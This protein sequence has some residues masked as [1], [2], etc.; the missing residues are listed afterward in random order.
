[1]V[2]NYFQQNEQVFREFSERLSRLSTN[3]VR[4][5]KQAASLASLLEL[6]LDHT[7]EYDKNSLLTTREGGEALLKIAR[8]RAVSEQELQRAHFL[9][10]KIVREVTIRRNGNSTPEEDLVLNHYSSAAGSDSKFDRSLSDDIWNLLPRRMALH[11]YSDTLGLRDQVDEKRKEV[12]KFLG[13]LEERI[14][15]HKSDLTKLASDYNFV[16][17]AGAFAS[18]LRKKTTEKWWS[19]S[20]TVLL[21]VLAVSLPIIFIFAGSQGVLA[22][23]LGSTWTPVVVAR[24]VAA[25]GTEVLVLYYFRVILR[26]YLAIRGQITNLQLRHSLCAF[27]EG[28]V[29]FAAKM[30]KSKES[31]AHF[32]TLIF[33]QLP[34]DLGTLPSTIDGVDQIVRLAEAVKARQ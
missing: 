6:I 22:E 5:E 10:A 29:D 34:A 23:A 8:N 9:L 19:F 14:I 27:I 33:G 25:I 32:E 11:V 12:E 18:L 2:A 16:G 21:G 13:D 30:G 3:T 17:L 31:L 15:S 4:A 28:Y 26:N 20:G 1:M 7:E 24:F